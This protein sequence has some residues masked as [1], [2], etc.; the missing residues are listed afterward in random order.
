M[1]DTY[2]TINK[3]MKSSANDVPELL[4]RYCSIDRIKQI[5]GNNRIYLASPSQMNDV[6]EFAPEYFVEYD[7]DDTN[8]ICHYF[9]NTGHEIVM[10]DESILLHPVTKATHDQQIKFT[11]EFEKDKSE[12]MF[13]WFIP[14]VHN[15]IEKFKEESRMLC[16]AESN[17]IELMWAHYAGS[18]KGVCLQFNIKAL[19]FEQRSFF[20]KVKYTNEPIKINIFELATNQ[21]N[22]IQKLIKSH[23]TKSLAWSYEQE[24]RLLFA[25]INDH[26]KG[27]RFVDY[28]K[29]KGFLKA[30]IFGLNTL[31]VEKL[32]VL[33]LLKDTG[34]KAFQCKQTK[35]NST[36]I[37]FDEISTSAGNNFGLIVNEDLTEI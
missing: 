34:T 10:K 28:S 36:E 16:F 30:V 15:F 3:W 12:T 4:Y 11:G 22:F 26:W 32:E 7:Q 23:V 5:L 19:P 1:E 8:K 35:V 6:Y 17:K 14:L 37:N 31:E 13:S 9:M 20:R 21:P 29:Q 18:H 2:E 27:F 33:E 24:W 25:A